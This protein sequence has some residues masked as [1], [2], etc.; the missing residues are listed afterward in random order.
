LCQVGNTLL[1]SNNATKLVTVS[2]V[3]RT[4][5]YPFKFDDPY[6]PLLAH[7][8]IKSIEAPFPCHLGMLVSKNHFEE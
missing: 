3:L 7:N 8:M 2:E 4:I 1:V 6:V 5:I